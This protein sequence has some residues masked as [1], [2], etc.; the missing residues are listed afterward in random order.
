MPISRQQ[1]PNMHQWYN[2]EMVFSTQS[3]WQLID[4]TLE[5]QLGEVFS[6]W[7]VQRCYKQDKSRIYLVVRQLPASKD[8]YTEVEVSMALEAV[9][10]QWP[11][12]TQ[13]TEK[14]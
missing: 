13:Q 11:M 3:M 10:R 4:P 9:I 2:S 1:V 5:E 8:M 14:T 7:F 6:V 12:K